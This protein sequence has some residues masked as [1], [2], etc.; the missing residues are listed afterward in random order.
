M[1]FSAQQK[2][3]KTGL[4]RVNT[5]PAAK[6]QAVPANYPNHRLAI[7]RRTAKKQELHKRFN[8]IAILQK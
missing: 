5:N 4:Q 7:C 6:V 3:Q 2:A 8:R 1:E